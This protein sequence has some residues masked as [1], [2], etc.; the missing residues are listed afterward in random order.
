MLTSII[1]DHDITLTEDV[2]HKV[3]LCAKYHIA[4]TLP[5]FHAYIYTY[6]DPLKNCQI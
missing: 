3:M 2:Y 4:G 1:L 6:G 5:L